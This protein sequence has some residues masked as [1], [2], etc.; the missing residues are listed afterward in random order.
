MNREINQLQ[1]GHIYQHKSTNEIND[2]MNEDD[3]TNNV[4]TYELNTGL[5]HPTILESNFS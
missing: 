1:P 2:Q 3:A 4:E 5:I